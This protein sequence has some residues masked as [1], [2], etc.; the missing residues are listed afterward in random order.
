MKRGF[1]FF[2]VLMLS[3]CAAPSDLPA[4]T[5]AGMQVIIP[6][7][8]QT[9]PA[10]TQ[11]ATLAPAPTGTAPQPFPAWAADFAEPI[12]KSLQAQRPAFEDDFP[13]ICIDEDKKWKVCATPEQRNY[14]QEPLQDLVFAT[15]R[16]TLDLQPD[17]QNGYAL[18]N[19]GWF[20]IVPNSEK[21]PYYA[22]IDHGALLLT[23][24]Q[25]HERGDFWVYHRNLTARNFVLTF[26]VEFVSAQPNDSFRWEYAPSP[27]ERAAFDLFSNKTWRFSWGAEQNQTGALNSFPPPQLN[28]LLIAQGV[29]CA[30]YINHLPAAYAP[31]CRVDGDGALFPQAQRFHLM[32]Q[33]GRE[34]A[35]RIDNVKMWNLDEP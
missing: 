17:L 32:A 10:A 16:P 33:V 30:V 18:L 9:L 13:S 34:A 28:I 29:R 12:F 35:L 4:A 5:P 25:P 2:L 7:P 20:Y 8:N 21:N 26:D 22:Q 15:P 23:L 6:Y 24:P 27:A 14:Y 31:N 19:S 3:A 1:L 11:T